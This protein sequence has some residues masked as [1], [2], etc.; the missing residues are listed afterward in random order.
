V[1]TGVIH[2]RANGRSKLPS[3]FMDC[4]IQTILLRN[5]MMLKFIKKTGF[6]QEFVFYE[7]EVESSG[8]DPAI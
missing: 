7:N 2:C 8:E 4:T 1:A 5:I 3:Y 6:K